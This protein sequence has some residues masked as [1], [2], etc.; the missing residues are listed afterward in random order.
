MQYI[1]LFFSHPHGP[2]CH[3]HIQALT[4]PIS[5]P[6]LP[7][8]PLFSNSP[9]GWHR[10]WDAPPPLRH[11]PCW[12]GTRRNPRAH[13][14]PQAQVWSPK[15]YL[16]LQAIPLQASIVGGHPC[17]GEHALSH[18]PFHPPPNQPS[19][20]AS[21]SSMGTATMDELELP[22]AHKFLIQ[23]LNIVSNI[24]RRP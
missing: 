5:P 22:K 20:K 13:I 15:I 11:Q 19:P 3:T 9:K 10:R 8:S 6:L 7:L 14:L 1:A 2:T 17:H 4:P 23:H 18:V 12:S 24:T 21:S 16:T